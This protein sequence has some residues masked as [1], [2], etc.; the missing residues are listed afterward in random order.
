M[1]KV[2]KIDFM[3][4][5]IALKKVLMKDTPLHR[6]LIKYDTKDIDHALLRAKRYIRLE[7]IQKNKIV[8]FVATISPVLSSMDGLRRLEEMV[9]YTEKEG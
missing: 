6:N 7:D 3:L 4:A 5:V 8:V 2:D 1:V 9:L